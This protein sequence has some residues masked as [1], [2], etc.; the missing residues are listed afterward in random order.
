MTKHNLEQLQ[1]MWLDSAAI[2]RRAWPDEYGVR[3]W[4]LKNIAKNLGISFTHHDALEDARAAAE[5]VLR[6]CDASTLDITGWLRRIRQPIKQPTISSAQPVRREGNTEGPLYGETVVFTGSPKIPRR[7][8]ADLAAT[9]G[10]HVVPNVTKKATILVVGT[11][12][13]NVL[14]GYEKSSKQRKA[15]SLI[16]RG[17]NIQILSEQDFFEMV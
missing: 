17:A 16:A 2:A 9:S 10:C 4:S 7:K 1:V 15:E 11:Q 8:A 5:I 6:A 14:N 13:K 12:N 3:G